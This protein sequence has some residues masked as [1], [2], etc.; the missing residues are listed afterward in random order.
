MNTQDSIAAIATPAGRGG[1]GVIRV[2]GN[3]AKKIAL[4]ML[5]KIP[6]A[7]QAEYLPFL[8]GQAQVVDQGIALFFPKPHSFTGEDVLELQGHG[9]PIILDMLLQEI[10]RQ[11][12]R[13]AQ[14]GEFSQRAF[15]NDKIDLVQAEAIADLIDASSKQAARC[16]VQTLQGG[17]SDRIDQLVEDTI[18]LRIFIEAA[19]DFPEEEIDFLEDA[20][21]CHRIQNLV[22]QL[23]DIEAGAQQGSLLR[24]GLRLVIAGKPNAGKSSLLNRLADRESAIV[25]PIP[26]TTRDVLREHIQIAGL[27]IHLLDTAGL[28]ETHDLVEQEGVRRAWREMETADRILLL[29][30]AV[31]GI[32]E[33]EIAILHQLNPTTPLTILRNKIDLNQQAPGRDKDYFYQQRRIDVLNI[34]AKTGDGIEVLRS[35]LLET[36]GYQQQ[37]EG[38]FLAR[39]RHLDAL[40]RAKISMNAAQ[41]E[42]LHGKQ[43]ELM[44]EQLRRVQECLSEIT[45][46]FTSD[47]LLGKIF[48][49]F[50]IGK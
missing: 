15:L 36:A 23:S 35:Y 11:G 5:G 48:S 43:G 39:R 6:A 3:A 2:S 47:D 49:S 24:E 41:Q 19:I 46:S 26:G 40:H 21:L 8:D 29:I 1:I 14:P 27:P 18:A 34:S 33:E 32:G 50:C 25:T 30:D 38:S 28:R 16:A 12:V 20:S 13:L 9:G 42:L 37:T 44:A 7:R 45:G 4:A 10:L 22:N 31:T 17:F